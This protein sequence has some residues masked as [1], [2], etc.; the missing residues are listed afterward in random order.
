MNLHGVKV[1]LEGCQLLLQ[2]PRIPIE[3]LIQILGPD[4][5]EDLSRT[6][7]QSHSRCSHRSEERWSSCRWSE[8]YITTTGGRLP[9]AAPALGTLAD[10]AKKCL[11]LWLFT[12]MGPRSSVPPVVQVQKH[13]HRPEWTTDFSVA[14]GFLPP[15]ATL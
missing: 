1:V 9:E 8:V 11:A 15:Q 7:V 2:V 3:S 14:T 12:R 6:T 13:T 4:V 10:I 5:S